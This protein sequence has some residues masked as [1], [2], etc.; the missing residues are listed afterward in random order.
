M[1]QSQE[2][3]DTIVLAA[4]DNPAEL[5]TAAEKVRVAGYK[6]FDCHSPFPIHGMDHAM[7]EKRSPLG[8][9]AGVI[10]FGGVL[11]MIGFTYW[12]SVIAYPVVISGKP[13]FSYQAY[14][15]PIFAVGVLSGALTSILGMLA[16]NK[17]PRLFHPL[18]ESEQFAR[19][20]D[21]GFFVSIEVDD[22]HPSVEDIK[23]FLGSIGGQNVEVV[24]G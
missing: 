10:G 2:K 12:V 20:S 3:I 11:F 18:F 4:F 14:F 24:T 7:G 16:L 21:D 23:T 15:P 5:L 13:L 19:V 9:F 1:S 6:N 8:W 22:A 17:L